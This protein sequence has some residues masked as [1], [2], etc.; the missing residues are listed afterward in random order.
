MPRRHKFLPSTDLS[1]ALTARIKARICVMLGVS[2]DG[3]MI[4]KIQFFVRMWYSLQAAAHIIDRLLQCS[5]LG[6]HRAKKMFGDSVSLSM[7]RKQA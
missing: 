7:K 6:A 5:F 1:A 2:N 3:G 4:T